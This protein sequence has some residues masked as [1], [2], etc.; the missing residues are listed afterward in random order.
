[1]EYQNAITLIVAMEHR[2]NW[3]DWGGRWTRRNLFMRNLKQILEDLDVE[4]TMPVQPVLTNQPF[5]SSG[6]DLEAMG[7]AGT[8]QRGDS[9]AGRSLREGVSSF[10]S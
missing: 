9:G 1:M 7:N 10:A 3:Q 4:Y 8:F 6:S 5:R 2:P